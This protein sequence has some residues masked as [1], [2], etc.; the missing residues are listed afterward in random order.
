[1][2]IREIIKQNPSVFVMATADDLSDFAKSLIKAT[3]KLQEEKQKPDTL[4]S[5]KQTAERLNVDYSSLW[6]WQKLGYLKPTRV[7]GKVMYKESDI[8]RILE[9]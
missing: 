7:G 2:E 5:R 1:M 9:G 3:L 6:R 4:V 8:Q